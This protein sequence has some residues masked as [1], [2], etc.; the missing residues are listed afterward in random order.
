MS[1]AT[2]PVVDTAI[3]RRPAARRHILNALE[4]LDDAS[5]CAVFSHAEPGHGS[6]A[7]APGR[8]P[9]TL[10]ERASI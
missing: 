5:W 2:L 7:A 8:P 3:P 6:L 4:R 10:P 1:P 9:A